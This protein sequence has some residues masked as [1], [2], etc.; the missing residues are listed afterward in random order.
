MVTASM[1]FLRS[2]SATHVVLECEEG[3]EGP[4]SYEREL[5]VR[6]EPFEGCV[7]MMEVVARALRVLERDERVGAEVEE[8]LVR[9]LRVM[10][11]FQREHLKPGMK[12]RVKMKKKKERR[13][14]EGDD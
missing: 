9:V 1:P 8:A 11:G 5:V 6:K 7:S 10:V 14:E 12:A 2:I 3:V 4:I 13:I